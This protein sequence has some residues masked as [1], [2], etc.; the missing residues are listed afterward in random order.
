MNKTMI[1]ARIP[2][3]LG[4]EIE[5]LAESTRRSK[6]FLITEALE[7]YVKRQAWLV[8]RIDDAVRDA[9]ESGEYVSEEDMSAWLKS[10]GKP[11]ELPPPK[12]RRRDELP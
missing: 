11:D 3:K 9:D 10:W 6:A 12:L 7:D 4:N 8:K 2:A 5:A 1:S